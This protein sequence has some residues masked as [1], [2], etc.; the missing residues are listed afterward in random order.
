MF[1]HK[2]LDSGRNLRIATINFAGS[3][4]VAKMN[5]T[6][7]VVVIGGG[8][9]GMLV[10]KHCKEHGLHVRILEQKPYVGGVWKVRNGGSF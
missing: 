4:L 10:A 3:V 8:W 1:I 2:L 5:W 6:G 9:S 7:D